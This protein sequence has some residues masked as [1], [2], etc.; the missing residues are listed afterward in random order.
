MRWNDVVFL[1]GM[2]IEFLGVLVLIAG[3]ITSQL[4]F[5][6]AGVG[7]ICIGPAVTFIRFRR[8]VR[9]GAGSQDQGIR[10]PAG[11]MI[12]Y[13]DRL[14]SISGDSITFHRYSFP[15][16]LS[17]RQVFFRDIVCIDVK[18][19]AIGSGKW[20]IAGSGD[21]QTWFPLDMDRPSRDKTFYA[22][23]KGQWWKIGFTVENSSRVI[24]VLKEKGLPVVEIDK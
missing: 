6:I 23:L 13:Q 20:R 5:I 8:R 1:P 24:S 16:F 17:D 7:I 21:F 12:L 19:T 2:I 9:R 4:M 18:K 10:T 3:F 15:L 22:T 14:V 11:S